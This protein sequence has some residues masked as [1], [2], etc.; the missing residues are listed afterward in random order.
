MPSI[1]CTPSPQCA[2]RNKRPDNCVCN[3]SKPALLQMLKDAAARSGDA[4]LANIP[5]ISD[6]EDDRP[7]CVS[8]PAVVAV[9]GAPA[10]STFG[11]VQ[12]A[13]LPGHGE[14]VV[15][16][17]SF[18]LPIV[19]TMAVGSGTQRAN[20]SAFARNTSCDAGPGVLARVKQLC[21][22]K[23][24]CRLNLR[25]PAFKMPVSCG[26]GAATPLRLAVR[27]S[28]CTQGTGGSAH[29]NFRESL[30]AFLLTRGDHAWFG[31]GFIGNN[32]PVWFPEWSVDYGT[33]LAPMEINQVNRTDGGVAMI[34][35]RPWSKFD[36]SLNLD[37]YEATFLP[38]K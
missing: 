16:F 32:H 28:G 14:M 38:R 18:G 35:T 2:F 20:C 8:G 23:Q 24:S 21:D 1:T 12:L 9:T 34:A 33:P 10:N 36:I 37:T 7:V 6:S 15:D 4:T 19:A 26:G 11:S 3:T 13:C 25:D 5:Y 27:A 22:G 30:A 31:H 17:A 29:S